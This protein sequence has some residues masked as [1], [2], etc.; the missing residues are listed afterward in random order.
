MAETLAPPAATTPDSGTPAVSAV[1]AV[2]PAPESITTVLTGEVKAPTTEAPKT[3][4]DTQTDTKDAKPEPPAVPE[5]YEFKLP[6][7]MTL[8]TEALSKFEPIARKLGLDQER[9]QEVVNLYAGLK[10]ADTQR[11][12]DDWAKQVSD[13]SEAVKTDKELGGQ[14][15]DTNVA[16][17]QSAMARF[18]TPELKAA[19]ESTGLG[20]HPELI[21]AFTRIGKAMGEDTF[22]TAAPISEPRTAEQILYGGKTE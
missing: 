8:D 3:D 14:A 7:G 5:K 2:A 10:Q 16:A 4:G 19:L 9:A 17:A 21:R 6:D 20:N 15:F 18:G 22:R 1:P 13:W 11:Q 12:Q